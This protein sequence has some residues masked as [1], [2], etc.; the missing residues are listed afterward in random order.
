MFDFNNTREPSTTVNE[1]KVISAFIK[2]MMSDTADDP[3]APERMRLDAKS[4]LTCMKISDYCMTLAKSTTKLTESEEDMK[5]L[6]DI[7]EYVTLVKTGMET[8]FQSIGFS[9]DGMED[10]K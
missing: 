2:S 8:F 1:K 9:I 6:R 3:D 10:T 5:K 7:V 4:T